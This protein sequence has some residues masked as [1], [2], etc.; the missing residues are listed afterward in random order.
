MLHVASNKLTHTCVHFT[1]K[2]KHVAQMRRIMDYFTQS[3][4][5]LWGYAENVITV[6]D[7]CLMGGCTKVSTNYDTRQ[8]EC[9]LVEP[10]EYRLSYISVMYCLLTCVRRNAPQVCFFHQK[11]YL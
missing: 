9:L 1:S 3:G 6:G 8:R 10:R 7:L 5:P 11:A 4:K 2:L